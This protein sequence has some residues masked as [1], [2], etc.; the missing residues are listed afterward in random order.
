MAV[1]LIVHVIYRLGTG[2]LENGVVNLVNHLPEATYR[3]AIVC[4]TE[5]TCFRHRIRPKVAIYELHKREGQDF[6]L[7]LRLY[8]LFCRLRPAIVHTRNLATLECQLPA[9]LA[10]VPVR[11]H[12]EHGWDVFDPE[13]KNR[14]YRWLRRLFRPLIHRYIPLSRQLED[15]LITQVQVPPNKITRI[16]NGVDTEVF[17]PPVAGREPIP[18][19]PFAE[20]GLVLIGTVGRMHGVKDQVTLVQ[21]FITLLEAKPQLQDKVRLVMV[22]DGPLRRECE[23]LLA[24]AGVEHLAW[25]PGNR[26]DIPQVLRGL[27]LFVLPSR[28]EGISNTILEAMA[29]GL[30]VIATAVGGNGELVRDGVSGR[31]V[32]PADPSPLADALMVYLERPALRRAHGDQG[33]CLAV[34]Q[35]SLAKMCSAYGR[36]YDQLLSR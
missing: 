7:Y 29:T 36:V 20:P 8:R 35:H 15:Y 18:G 4:L 23:A 22:G 19:C 34:A 5:A 9:W 30:P 26:D 32:P 3:H 31:L 24:R 27:D 14:K 25:L 16:C 12:G 10:G 1:P 11:I 6:G 28:A 17:H 13:G 21:A 33:R 2:G